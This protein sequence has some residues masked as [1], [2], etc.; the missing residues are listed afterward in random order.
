M[1]CIVIDDR[2]GA[3]SQ[4]HLFILEYSLAIEFT[5]VIVRYSKCSI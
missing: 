4:N 3:E 1:A 2:S 5:N